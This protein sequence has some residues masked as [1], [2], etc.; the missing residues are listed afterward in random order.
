MD[1]RRH[2]TRDTAA[3]PNS[4]SLPLMATIAGVLRRLS[5][6]KCKLETYDMVNRLLKLTYLRQFPSVYRA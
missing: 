3:S 6:L 5:L 1:D 4:R 2:L